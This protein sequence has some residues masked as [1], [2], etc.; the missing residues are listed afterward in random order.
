[1]SAFDFTGRNRGDGFRGIFDDVRQ[2]LR[3]QPPVELRQHRLLLDIDLDID[4][5]I[6]DP[7]Q[8]HRLPNGI[9]DILTLDDGLRHARELGEFVDHFADVIDLTNDRFRALIENEPIFRD[10]LAELAAD[11]LGGQLNR[12]QRILDLVRDAAGDVRPCRGALRGDEFGDVVERDDVAF[13]GLRRLLLGAD[14]HGEIALDAVAA[15][16]DLTLQQPLR[17]AASRGHQFVEFGNDLGQ[18]LAQH[19]RFGMPDQFFRRTVENGDLS[20]AV[21]TDDASARG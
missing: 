11:A 20:L 3:D 5:G 8:E 2:P 6:A 10:H 19:F 4:I 18:R 14:A 1:M 21:D 16:F 17:T 7:H 12:R 13:V 15:D 9:G